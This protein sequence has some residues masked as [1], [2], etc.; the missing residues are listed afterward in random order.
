M[1]RQ[2]IF[3][4]AMALVLG[5]LVVVCPAW[6]QSEE[7]VV[8][9]EQT[10]PEDTF[11]PDDDEDLGM[12][13]PAVEDG[14]APEAPRPWAEGV[15]PEEQQAALDLFKAGN[16]LLK[17]SLFAQ[18]AVKYR[19]A[20]QHWDHPRIHYN[21]ALSLMSM[22]EPIAI[23]Q[24]LQ[25]ALDHGPDGLDE[26]KHKQA[27]NYL[28]LYASQIA[29]IEVRCEEP[30]AEVSVDGKRV[31]TGPGAYRGLVRIGEHRV[32]ASK[33]GYL[34][35]SKSLVLVPN[36][37]ARV[38]LELIALDKMTESRRRWSQWKP[39]AVVGGGVAVA[40]AGGF[41]HWRSIGNYEGYDQGVKDKCDD[42]CEPGE[43]DFEALQEIRDRADLQ[44]Q[45]AIGSYALGG[46]ALATGVVLVYLN[47]LRVFRLDLPGQE[48]S[49]EGSV[50]GAAEPAP[51][52]FIPLISP[53]GAGA[54]AA[55]RF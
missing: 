48:G 29:R 23:Y 40:A 12:D 52:S 30:G 20:L 5:L 19:E 10:L 3:V 16:A 28:K 53:D 27:E 18:A 4:M 51:V 44:Q 31:F 54:T 21:L 38:R 36:D 41:L 34:T 45:A 43:D 50:E 6:A 22:D 1:Q 37:E 35:A 39:W 11:L 49:V 15:P 2:R 33:A 14:G 13:R 17:D 46:A 24:S 25:K 7:D 32:V 55:F 8:G 42:G 9:T 47:R 26:D